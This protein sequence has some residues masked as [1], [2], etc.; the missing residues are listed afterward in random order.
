M[1]QLEA[2][3]SRDFHAAI[4]DVSA[5]ITGCGGWITNHQFYSNT[6]AM[7]AFELP[8][9]KVADLIGRFNEAQIST[10]DF[11]IPSAQELQEIKG[12]LNITF[13]HN[14]PDLRRTVPAF[15]T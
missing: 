15:D 5:A 10:R 12:Q 13:M 6:M 2:V 1:I 4:A 14:N 8:A 7:I 11:A 9:D 3:T